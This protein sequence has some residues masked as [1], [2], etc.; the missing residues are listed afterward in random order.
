VWGQVEV[1]APAPRIYATNQTIASNGYS[2]VATAWDNAPAVFNGAAVWQLAGG[3]N[4]YRIDDRI[5]WRRAS[6][7]AQLGWVADRVTSYSYVDGMIGRYKV[8]RCMRI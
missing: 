5:E 8:D 4:Q 3:A 2:G 7:H 6:D 1:S